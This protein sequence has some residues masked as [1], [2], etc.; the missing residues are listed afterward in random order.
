MEKAQLGTRAPARDT[1]IVAIDPPAT[2]M[3]VPVMKY[4]AVR[5]S[6]YMVDVGIGI[7]K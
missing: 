4:T 1:K 5:A 3:R 6:F 2:P 7:R